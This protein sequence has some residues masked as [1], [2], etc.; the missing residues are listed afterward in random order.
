[1]TK[2]QTQSEETKQLSFVNAFILEAEFGNR[3]I[4]TLLELPIKYSGEIN[5]IILELRKCTRANIDINK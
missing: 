3:L 5:P 2:K 4:N 1:M